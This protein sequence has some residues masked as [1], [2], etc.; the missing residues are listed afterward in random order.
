MKIALIGPAYPLRGGI[1]HFTALLARAL[2]TRGHRVRIFSFTRMYPGLLFPGKTQYDTSQETLPVESVATLDSINPFSWRRTG[3]IV[4][5]WNPDAVIFKYWMPFFA[6]AYACVARQIRKRCNARIIFLCHNILPHERHTGMAF[7]TRAGLGTAD[8]F[9]VMSDAVQA[10][11]LSFFPQASFARVPHPVYE[12]FTITT[13]KEA[14]RTQLGLGE[15]RIVLFFGYVRKYK[16][17]SVLLDAFA[18]ART[19]M[20][21]KLIVAGEI[22]GDKAEYEDKIAAHH[23]QEDVQLLDQY[24]ANEQ[25]GLYYAASDVVALPYLSA[26]QSGIVQVCYQFNKPV[27]ATDVGGLPE[28][29]EDGRTGFVVP[30]GDA[31]AFADALVRFYAE[32]RERDFSQQIEQIKERYSWAHLVESIEKLL[33]ERANGTGA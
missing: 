16:G 3:A 27:I 17:L 30:A 32:N 28:V 1:A 10:Q 11:L 13:T 5:A 4:S 12:F 21:M 2:Q 31:H 33:R 29:V 23:L 7:L 19:R 15:G 18:L 25:V 22:Y 24:I 14:A 20:P 6:P 26:T 9:I 8:H